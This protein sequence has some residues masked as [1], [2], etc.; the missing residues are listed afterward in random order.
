MA[1]VVVGVNHRTAPVEVR[2]K[3]A[4]AEAEIPAALAELKAA[5]PVGEA[6]ILST[7]NRVELYLAGEAEAA[8]LVRLAGDF[9]RRNRGL[10]SPLDEALYHHADPESL[11]HLFRVAAGMD[12]MVLGETEILGQLKQAYHLALKA[13]GTARLLNKAFQRAFN[14]AK[15]IR[16]HTQIQRGT[17]SVS[18]VAVDMAGRIFDQLSRSTVLVIGAG[19]TGSKA[20]R[21]MMSRGAQAVRVTNRSPERARALA[22]ELGGEAVPFERWPEE[23]ERVEIVISSTSAPHYVLDE[24]LLTPRLKARHG[25]PLL[26]LDLAVPRDIDPAVNR[27]DGV[28]LCNVDDLQSIASEARQ[29]REAELERCNALIRERAREPLHHRPP[30]RRSPSAP[31]L[32]QTT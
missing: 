8:A 28:F 18:S 31:P 11:E 1:I 20:A 4:F 7:C 12:S 32:P 24:A 3:L 30:A 2:E 25:R 27:L 29:Q 15:H 5:G 13:G 10:A 22:A 23:L 21:A 16:T 9:L 19:D 14:V 26:L 6:V 17:V